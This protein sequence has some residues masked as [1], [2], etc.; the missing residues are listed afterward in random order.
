MHLFHLHKI[1]ANSER[2]IQRVST[3]HIGPNFYESNIYLLGRTLTL[4]MSKKCDK[5]IIKTIERRDDMIII[6]LIIYECKI[7]KKFFHAER[8]DLS[9]HVDIYFKVDAI[10]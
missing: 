6:A 5:T 2:E 1:I 3:R 10:Q 7:N 8:R 4:N 9:L